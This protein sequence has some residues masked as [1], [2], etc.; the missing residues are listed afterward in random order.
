[1][2]KGRLP[3]NRVLHPRPNPIVAAM[4]AL[5]DL[6]VDVIVLHGPAGCGF[7]ASR[8]LEEAGVRVMTSGMEESDLIFGA[9]ENLINVLRT[10]DKDFSPKMIGLVGSCASMII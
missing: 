1:M 3:M 2:H 4:Y 6:E 7:M 5:R 9:E 8:R 10:V